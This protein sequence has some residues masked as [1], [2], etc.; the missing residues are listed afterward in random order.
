MDLNGAKDLYRPPKNGGEIQRL[1]QR[2]DAGQKG[3]SSPPCLLCC[4]NTRL[5]KVVNDSQKQERL[6]RSM[7]QLEAKV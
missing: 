4:T 2:A 6:G 1:L 5:K 3:G 7:V